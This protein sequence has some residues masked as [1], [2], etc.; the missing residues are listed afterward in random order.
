MARDELQAML[1]AIAAHEAA[2]DKAAHD[3]KPATK[4]HTNPRARELQAQLDEWQ[5]PLTMQVAKQIGGSYLLQLQQHIEHN[6][7][8]L[9]R[10]TAEPPPSA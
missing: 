9:A 7:A 10:L 3:T 8:E 5:K 2:A 4:Q 1:Q 6:K